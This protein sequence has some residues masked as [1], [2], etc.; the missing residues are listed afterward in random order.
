MT[1]TILADDLTGACDTGTLFVGKGPVPVAIWPA[2]PGDGPVRVVDTETRT[3][4]P[5]IAR[6]RV[7]RA[8]AAAPADRYF[9]KIDSTLRG[10]IGPE[11]E[12]LMQATRAPLALVAPAFPAQRRIVVDRVLTIDG[13]PV[14]ETPIA[15]DRQFPAGSAHGPRTSSVIDLLRP[16]LDR[17]VAWIP[18]AEVRAA[19]SGLA[20]RLGRLAGTVVVADAE[21]DGDLAALVDAAFELEPAPLLVGSAGLGGALAAR[22]GLLT[23]HVPLPAG[24]WLLVVGSLHPASRR[25]A[26]AA[27]HAGL[28]VIASADEPAGDPIDVARRLAADAAR[29]LA[30]EPYDIVAVTGGET[31]LALC[32]ALDVHRIP[33]EGPPARGLALG[34]IRV[35]SGREV[36]LLTKAGG[37]GDPDL[38]VSLSGVEPA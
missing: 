35:P 11:V 9:K 22:L 31:A 2:A 16:Q 20:A 25:Q 1:L 5:S 13:F 8:A 24:R 37:F 33:L 18:L 3:V 7:V 30:A 26:A 6:D 4:A 12:A 28:R 21:R 38:F 17:P 36:C 14:A 23:D 34:R 10:R 32:Q 29:V 15:R 27:R 19:T